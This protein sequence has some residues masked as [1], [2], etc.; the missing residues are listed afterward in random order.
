M[1]RLRIA[2]LLLTLALGAQAMGGET[3]EMRFSALSRHEQAWLNPSPELIRLDNFSAAEIAFPTASGKLRL[4]VEDGILTW[5]RNDDGVL[6]E[7]DAPGID[8]RSRDRLELPVLPVQLSLHGEKVTYPLTVMHANAML[9]V[10]G[11]GAC[12]RATVGGSEV[13]L[14]DANL[15]GRF[16]E[17]GVDQISV[18]PPKARQTQADDAAQPP[19]LRPQPL[20]RYVSLNGTLYELASQK[21]G[22]QLTLTP[23]AGETTTLAL[24]LHE[25]AKQASL[26]LE[27]KELEYTA[28][29]LSDRP[30]V[31]PSGTYKILGSELIL[32]IPQDVIAKQQEP[33]A[34]E[35]LAGWLGGSTVGT[36][37]ED[38]TLFLTGGADPGRSLTLTPGEQTLAVGLPFT[39]EVKAIRRKDDP[40]QIEVRDALLVGPSGDSYSATCYSGADIK[41]TLARQL[42]GGGKERPVVTMEY[43]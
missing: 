11:G 31:F 38:P 30:A 25:S 39:L 26:Q 9:V 16:D 13:I 3:L 21:Q 42:R 14:L 29:V 8:V 34:F 22:W 17:R 37:D 36:V 28:T 10:L 43:G 6:D 27:N 32:N 12:L 41:G 35:K 7:Q 18:T 40:N 20:G 23:Y 5:D 19:T 1:H 33:D 4:K 24:Q 15:D 2:T